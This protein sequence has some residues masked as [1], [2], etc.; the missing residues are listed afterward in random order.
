M[1]DRIK[2]FVGCSA[3]GEDAE[4]L[5]VLEYT[6]RKH[7]SLPIDIEWMKMSRDPNSFWYVEPGK[8]GWRTE[9]WATPFSGFRWGI[10]EECGFKGK[11][12]YMDSD[13][14]IMDDL[15]KLWNQ[16]FQPGKVIM[17]KGGGE[18][19][20]YCVALWD[21]ENARDHILPVA[22][23]H[24]VPESHQ[25][26]MAFMANNQ[27]LV[28]QFEGNWNCIDG[29]SYASL[30]DPDIK[31]I[32]YSDMSTQPQVRH[33]LKRLEGTGVKHWFD[34]QVKEHWRK[35]LIELFDKLLAEAEQNGYPVSKYVP[36][37]LY[38]AYNKE[39]QKDYKNAHQWSR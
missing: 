3:N 36:N 10:P 20:R 27:D 13:M 7:S 28:Q 38:G 19:W 6:A 35:D 29:E 31:I 2:L 23:F 22:R 25:R 9:T 37:D 32:H 8:G 21:C 4:S 34:G 16:K 11:A 14:I 12:I 26:M 18:S 1:S 24:T 5:A 30:D 15:A 39:S 17:A 33:A